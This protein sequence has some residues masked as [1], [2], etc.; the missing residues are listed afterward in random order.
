MISETFCAAPWTVHCINANGTAGVCCVNRAAVVDSMDHSTMMQ[1]TAVQQMKQ[2]MLAGRP[3]DGC[4]KCYDNERS[5]VYS[6][7]NLYNKITGHR[8]DRDRLSDPQY[9]NRVW[10]DL[11]LGNKCNQKCR[12]CGPHNST[13]WYKD[14]KN[15]LDL[16]WAHTG[17]HRYPRS[18]DSIDAIPGI[19]ASMHNTR[20]SFR[21]EL[22]GGEPLYMD[23]NRIL[24]AEM[25]AQGLHERTEEL[26]IITNGTQHD[27][28]L[29]DMLRQFPHIDLGLSIDATGKLHEYVRGTNMSW[30]QCRRSWSK[31]VDLP[32]I[33]RLRLC[34]TVYAYTVFDL[35]V[36]RQW[37][38][39]EFGRLELMSDALLHEPRYLSISILPKHLRQAA[40]EQLP[41]Q[42]DMI[43]V[44]LR[45]A[46]SQTDL[47]E[48]RERFKIF[49]KRLDAIRSEDLT[50]LVPELSEL[51]S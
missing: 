33:S 41:V 24:L 9:E 51:L 30:D 25:I 48:Q 36:L 47:L 8:L 18:T 23:S 7:R 20:D 39:Q 22:K 44:F 16:D 27:P 21:I 26:R 37:A 15:F 42:D 10:Y 50:S 43:P 5:G 12:I 46:E 11:S 2:D 4:A 3:A 38:H 35:P 28:R 34:N 32:N 31:I 40:A 13:A 17:W 14:A 45:E 49:T 6:L 19:I 29:L 1:S